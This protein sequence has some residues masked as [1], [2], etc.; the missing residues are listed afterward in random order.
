MVERQPAI[1]SKTE[2]LNFLLMSFFIKTE[3]ER[4]DR[5][6]GVKGRQEK[7]KKERMRSITVRAAHYTEP[8]RLQKDTERGG[9]TKK[10]RDVVTQSRLS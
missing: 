3:T 8:D 1:D 6:N 9:T 10:E 7:R 2:P 5:R 4:K